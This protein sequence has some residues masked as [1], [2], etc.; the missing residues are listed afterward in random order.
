M[1]DVT[2]PEI[3]CICGSTRV[4]DEIVAANRDLTLA[5]A[6]VLAPGVFGH[7]GDTITDE[8][9]AG[10][11]RL[12]FDKI[13]MADRVLVVNPGGYIG[14]STRNEIGFAARHGKP[15]DYTEPESEL[16]AWIGSVTHCSACGHQMEPAVPV[17]AIVNGKSFRCGCGG[18]VFTA[19]HNDPAFGCLLECNA[20]R[21]EYQPA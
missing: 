1:T 4:R 8:Q 20:C 11:D 21:A 17:M 16:S 12:H 10:L 3:V 2:R 14:E 18:N 5:G 6:I 13:L 7:S 9:K 15:V 19:V